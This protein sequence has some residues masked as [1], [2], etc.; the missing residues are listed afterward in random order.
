MRFRRGCRKAARRGA[1]RPKRAASALRR[2]PR[3]ARA[4]PAAL[5]VPPEA[6][7]EDAPPFT[8]GRAAGHLVSKIDP[9]GAMARLAARP[10]AVVGSAELVP[11]AKHRGSDRQSLEEQRTRQ[12][13]GRQPA[14]QRRHLNAVVDGLLAGSA[15]GRPSGQAAAV[16][17]H[18]LEQPVEV[19]ARSG[20]EVA[21][22]Q[23]RS[24]RRRAR[25]P[26]PERTR[27]WRRSAARRAPDPEGAP[28]SVQH[29]RV[30]RH[31]KW[32]NT[33]VF[34]HH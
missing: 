31:K 10:A 24:P 5:L 22:R 20:V 3:G 19:L 14:I 16:Q 30:C 32:S 4:A 6:A 13:G 18:G 25:R 26:G 17:H 7:L 28:R 23:P 33:G 15:H 2:R 29:P 27:S 12:D 21:V 9:P 34:E 11:R 8:G 1:A